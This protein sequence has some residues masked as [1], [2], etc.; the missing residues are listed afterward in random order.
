MAREISRQT[1]L[2]GAVGA[3]AAGAVLGAPRVG[4]DPRPSG[5]EGLST[6]LGGKVLLPDSPQFAGAKQVFNTNYNGSTPAAVVTPTS[7]ADV[8]KAMAFAAAHNLKVAPRS[9]GHSYTGASTANGTMVLDLRQLPGDANYD[10]ATGQ[11]TVTPATSLYTM[12]RTLAAVGRGVPTGT[13]PSV[14]AAGH[15]LGGG[16]G[17]QSRHAGLLCDQLTSASVVLPSGQAVTASAA[18]N[19]DLFWALR[20]G[21]GGNFGVTTS[22]TFATFP[23]KDVDAVNLN[24]PPQSFAQVL[25]GWQNWLRTADPNSWALAD[26]TV[27]AMGVHCRILATCPAGSGNSAAAAITQAV[28]IQP[29]GVE[30]HTFNYM[31]LVNYLAVG[32]LNPQPLGYVGGSDVFPTV[33]AAVAQGI[34]AAVN[35]FPRNAGRMLA[36]MHALDG[37]LATVAPAATAFPWR[38]QSALV[39]WYVETSGDPAPATNWLASAHQAVQQYSVGGYVNYLEAN[40]SPARYFGPNLSRLSAVR[41][42]YDPGR[43]MFSG[44]N[45]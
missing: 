17:A 35:A 42:K 6:A 7:A 12:H 44:L 14:G 40:Q 38:R 2:R 37:A 18:S 23:T 43:V 24:F 16:M 29:S 8:Q 31:D 34:A 30:T 36:I 13:C 1:F 32:N 21:G 3:L 27:D 22:L 5:W 10:A 4:A 41:Q 19:P 26:A 9:G 25:V 28:G 20:G 39:Q 15:A 45:Y 33:N 11:V